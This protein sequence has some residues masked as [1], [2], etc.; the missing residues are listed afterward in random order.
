MSILPAAD[1]AG[2]QQRRGVLRALG[3]ADLGAAGPRPA[4]RAP[5]RASGRWRCR[6]GSPG[7]TAPGTAPPAV[8]RACGGRRQPV[9]APPQAHQRGQEPR[10]RPGVAHVQLQRRLRRAGARDLAPAPHDGDATVGGVTGVRLDAHLEPEAA[11]AVD[12]HL[13]VL[14]PQRARQGGGPGGQRGQHER[15]V[16]HA[17]GARDRHARLYG[18]RARDDLDQSGQRHAGDQDNREP[19]R[20]AAPCLDRAASR[21]RFSGDLRCVTLLPLERV[22][23][24]LRYVL[25]VLALVLGAA[26]LWGRSHGRLPR[27]RHLRRSGHTGRAADAAGHPPGG[28]RHQQRAAPRLRQTS[29]WRSGPARAEVTVKTELGSAPGHGSG[30]CR[31][32]AARYLG[33]RFERHEDRMLGHFAD[34]SFPSESRSDP[35]QSD[36]VLVRFV[37]LSALVGRRRHPG[38]GRRAGPVRVA[39][40][41]ARQRGQAAVDVRVG[42]GQPVRRRQPAARGWPVPTASATC[43]CKEASS[44]S[45][46]TTPPSTESSAPA[47]CSSS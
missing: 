8:A 11:E 46:S 20:F 15:P 7:P 34:C 38:A 33:Q 31:R 9:A 42:I 5:R 14:A 12:H 43:P 17:L 19:R 29:P 16:G 25:M 18:P 30:V 32:P 3:H 23:V 40:V 24:R 22:P 35:V 1:L 28:R 2:E 36:P 6:S 39:G 47:R 37:V 21:R 27:R 10:R 45:P 13:R 4:S 41:V 44:R 26:L